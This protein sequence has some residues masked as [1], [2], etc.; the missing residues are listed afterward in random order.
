[1][2]GELA[3]KK[4]IVTGGGRG[5]GRA[6]VSRLLEAGASVCVFDVDPQAGAALAQDH[7]S[8]LC[9]TCDVSDYAA[10]AAA[11]GTYHERCGAADILV[12]NAGILYSAPLVRI[13]D[14][15]LETH[16]PAMWSQVIAAD[17]TSVFNMSV[18]V[19]AKMVTTRTKGVI[20]N[21]SSISAAG[22]AGQSAYAAAKAGVDALTRTWAKELGL[23]GIRVAGIAPGFADT[24]STHA[25]VNAGL[26]KDIVARVP[27]RRL[28]K[29][30]EIAD[31]VVFVARNGFVNGTIVAIDGG[32]VV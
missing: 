22:N 17:L 12:N 4:A 19:V 3:G 30:E 27:L 31:A 15:G 6:I 18:G 11:L 28:A 26:L 7:P 23:Y 21:I 32:L 8:V 25:A 16:D 13:T 20:I 24:P 5:L 29:A 9:L 10:A 14:K 2:T 1:L